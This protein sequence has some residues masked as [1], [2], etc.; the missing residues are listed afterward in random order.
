MEVDFG[1]ADWDSYALWYDRLNELRPY[2]CMLDD[3][4]GYLHSA[5]S[6]VLDAGCGTGNLI[7]R[8]H[9]QTTLVGMDASEAMLARAKEKCA[10]VLFRC[11]DLNEGLPFENGQF[12]AI[13]C[14]N[15]LYALE[16]PERA[17]RE[18]F[19]VLQTDGILVLATPKRGY[20]NGL[21]LKGHCRSDKPDDYW[22]GIHRN[23]E[24]E[25]SLVHEA[26]GDPELAE[27]FLRIV[28]FNR[29]IAA[30]KSFRFFEERELRDL[31]AL[32]GLRI[33]A[34]RETYARQSH[35]LAARKP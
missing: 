15:T 25:K 18:F 30:E 21:I 3:V 1:K 17:L 28:R 10:G 31:V 8:L 27:E 34:H 29:C 4:V 16:E 35:L 14:V 24:R 26:I 33:V 19:R 9:E 6:P 23:A 5:G 20:E 12:G 11:A 22:R 32:T 2:A 13:A 7:L